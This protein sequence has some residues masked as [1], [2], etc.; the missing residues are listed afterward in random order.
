[1]L[2]AACVTAA[3]ASKP[4]DDGYAT[5]SDKGWAMAVPT[6]W[7]TYRGGGPDTPYS[8]FVAYPKDIPE[9]TPS[10][11]SVQVLRFPRRDLDFG[12][13]SLKL[14]RDPWCALPQPTQQ[15]W[16]VCDDT[17]LGIDVVS[18]GGRWGV[19]QE[20]RN[21]DGSHRWTLVVQNDCYTYA[22]DAR[23][24]ADQLADQTTIVSHMLA[25][26]RIAP[27]SKKAF[28]VC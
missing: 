17:R 25:S 18:V 26:A 23:V 28:G 5:V 6:E 2:A 1:V 9:G 14:T 12:S 16:S 4:I 3:A 11:S 27:R 20:V 13:A 10:S 15:P 24:S 22:A 19:L 21:Q 8:V 7:K